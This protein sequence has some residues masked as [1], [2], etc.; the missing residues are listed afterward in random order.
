MVA[1]RD[2]RYIAM[3]EA[4]STREIVHAT[5]AAINQP[6]VP[7]PQGVIN[8]GASIPFH[9]DLVQAP[10]ITRFVHA[11]PINPHVSPTVLL[12]EALPGLQV[13]QENLI[14]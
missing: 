8:S 1:S 6:L 7:S 5:L 13:L 4:T 3:H 14:V 10:R 9:S 12:P 2:T 11:T